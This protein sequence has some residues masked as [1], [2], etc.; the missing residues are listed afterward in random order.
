MRNAIHAAAIAVCVA[1]IAAGAGAGAADAPPD[2]Q[3]VCAEATCRDGGYDLALGLGAG[4]ATSI[5]VP[6]SPIVLDGTLLIFPGETIAIQFDVDGDRLI[7]RKIVQRYSARYPVPRVNADHSTFAN[8]D[9]AALP[10]LKGGQA[11]DEDLPPNTLVVS[12]GQLQPMADPGM[13]LTLQQNTG[14]MMK[15]D[16]LIAEM[17]GTTYNQHPSSTCPIPPNIS[18]FETWGNALG[19]LALTNFRLLPEGSPM[20]CQ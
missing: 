7:P 5:S 1:F 4:R 13:V 19:P 2:L 8:P 10:H 16:A 18:G 11:K 12:Y 20:V 17:A 3:K 9:D 15:V 6:H 14:R